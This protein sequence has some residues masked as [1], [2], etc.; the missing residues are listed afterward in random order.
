MVIY[1]DL[2]LV[3]REQDAICHLTIAKDALFV[4]L[5]DNEKVLESHP[6]VK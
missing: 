6:N 5:L 1:I 2:E 3:L 4:F